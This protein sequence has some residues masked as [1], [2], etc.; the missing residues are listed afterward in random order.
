MLPERLT[1]IGA[2]DQR[3]WEEILDGEPEKREAPLNKRDSTIHPLIY[4][5]LQITHGRFNTLN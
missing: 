2:D 5:I 4:L 3:F 1:V